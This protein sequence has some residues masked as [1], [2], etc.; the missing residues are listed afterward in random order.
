L[1]QPVDPDAA[2]AAAVNGNFAER[3]MKILFTL[4]CGK[5][6]SLVKAPARSARREMPPENA[7]TLLPRRDPGASPSARE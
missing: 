3:R 1:V 5:R 7:E 2:A 6:G 4:L